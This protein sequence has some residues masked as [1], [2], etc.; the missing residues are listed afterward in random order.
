MLKLSFL[1]C[2]MGVYQS[3]LAG[4]PWYT[5]TELQEE[6]LTKIG[7]IRA[8]SGFKQQRIRQSPW[9]NNGGKL[10]HPKARR[11]GQSG[12]QDAEKAAVHK[13]YLT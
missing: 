2:K 1:F 4:N 13:G 3:K 10:N 5:Q 11:Q 12:D 6:S 7:H 9:A 8:W